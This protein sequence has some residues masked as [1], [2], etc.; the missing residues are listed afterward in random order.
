MFSGFLS[1]DVDLL[2]RVGVLLCAV[3]IVFVGV[4]FVLAAEREYRR[5][6]VSESSLVLLRLRSLNVAYDFD[7]TL[8]SEYVV[9]RSFNTKAKFDRCRVSD[10]FDE[11]IREDGTLRELPAR[12]DRNR[13]LYRRYLAD[14]DAI[15]DENVVDV[16][17]AVRFRPDLYRR[18]ESELFADEL[19]RPVTSCFV[20]VVVSYTSPRGRNHYER[21]ERFS[22]DMIP[23]RLDALR[24]RDELMSS[25]DV[26]KRRAR[27]Q[28][29]DSLRYRILMRD[30]FR[31]RVCG[32]TADDGIKLHV[33]HIVPVSRGGETVESNLQTLCET[34]NWG[35]SDRY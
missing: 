10:V 16:A 21:D 17:F 4:R 8:R 27:S 1:M 35:K 9:R 24:R 26:R 5:C 34:C 15:D 31:C 23:V 3:A 19:R 30:G 7:T 12:V 6:V 20:R 29:T 14:V 13:E 28:M 32:R 2:L 25:E 11:F 22:V 33:D 18:V